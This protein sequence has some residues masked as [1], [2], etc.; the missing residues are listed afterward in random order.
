MAPE[1]VNE[2]RLK[3]RVLFDLGH[4][5]DRRFLPPIYLTRNKGLCGLPGVRDVPPD[6]FI[7]VYFLSAR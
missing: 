5:L 4:K 2:K 3:I 7:Q 1:G 6:H